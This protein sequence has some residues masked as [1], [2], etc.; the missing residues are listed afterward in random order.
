METLRILFYTDSADIS[1]DIHIWGLTRLEQFIELKLASIVNIE[2]RILNRH[3]DYKNGHK[4]KYQATKLRKAL[5]DQ[6][7]ELWIFGALPAPADKPE[8]T[9][10]EI[11][12][13]TEWMK[14]GGVFITGDHSIPMGRATCKNSHASFVNLGSALGRQ[15]PRAKELRE[16]DGPPTGCYEGPLSSRDNFNTQEGNNPLE[17][18]DTFLQ[19]DGIPQQLYLVPPENPHRLFWWYFDEATH[20]MVYISRFPDHIHE[21]LLKFP[22]PQGADWPPGSPP[23]KLVAQGR[24]KRFTDKFIDLVSVF[25]GTKDAGRIV[26]DSSFHHYINK[27]LIGI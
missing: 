24:D 8:L 10:P 11:H 19:E 5:L 17:L 26:A 23:P 15:I 22:I 6:F 9:K 20:Q 3:I 2:I 16:W 25:E 7:D 1:E 21:G 12:D 13:L 27:N 14:T 18:D 4:Y